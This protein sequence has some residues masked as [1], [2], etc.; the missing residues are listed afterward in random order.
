MSVHTTKPYGLERVRAVLLHFLLGKALTSL[1]SIAILLLLAREL[2]VPE[3]G[4]F[5]ILQ[6]LVLLVGMVSSLGV[7]Q[8]GMRYIPELRESG[9]H[10]ALYSLIMTTVT[11]RVL[12]AA[13]FLTLV[14]TSTPWLKN[15]FDLAQWQHFLNLY[16]WVG[17][18]RLLN[19]YLAQVLESLL[20][21]R[22]SQYSLA[23][24]S[25]IKL[26]SLVYLALDGR[27]DLESVIW[28]EFFVELAATIGLATGLARGWIMDDAR[29]HGD[30][31]WYREHL[32]RLRRYGI[33]AYIQTLSTSL[34]G[35]APN[36]L[37]AG[38]YFSPV[39]MGLFGFVSQIS[40][41]L[42]RY[43]PTRMLQGMIRPIYF[44]RYTE[45]GSVDSINGIADMVLRV[46][47][48]MLAFPMV[49]MLSVGAELLGWLTHGKYADAAYLT[50]AYM[51]V[52]VLESLWSQIELVAQST[53]KND[54]LVVGNII[55]SLS[56]LTALPFIGALGL[57]SLVVANAVGN[58]IA[59]YWLLH[60]LGRSGVYMKVQW[61]ALV[62]IFSAVGLS[63]TLAALWSTSENFEILPK[64]TVT[65]VVFVGLLS[66]LRVFSSAEVAEIK[67]LLSKKRGSVAHE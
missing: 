52:L 7:N 60:R 57:W 3:Y 17:G 36:R 40:D 58:I 31:H 59:V 67:M 15:W 27:I 20:W 32:V 46:S 63:G 65:L 18:F 1:S 44:A 54:Y 30:M 25:L 53:E 10:R 39:D 21:Q 35:S 61:W 45:S 50:A 62:R 43:L 2:T 64:A 8:L 24:T 42:R 38:R 56:L 47:V 14:G 29:S 26:I 22:V 48:L 33:W 49:L 16:L 13:V 9:N 19:F 6:A 41:L 5:A 4:V 66:W 55:L 37:L 51:G 34:Y 23:L 28:V 12:T 11:L